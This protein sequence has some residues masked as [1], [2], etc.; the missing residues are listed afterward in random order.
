[1]VRRFV[2]I[3]I[4]LLLPVLAF[5]QGVPYRVALGPSGAYW[6]SAPPPT[7]T[8][9]PSWWNMIPNRN[10]LGLPPS[11]DCTGQ[12]FYLRQDF[13]GRALGYA[14][15]WGSPKTINL[16]FIFIEPEVSLYW[17]K[18]KFSVGGVNGSIDSV[19]DLGLA[20]N[21]NV[22][23]FG[24]NLRSRDGT[25]FKYT[26]MFAPDTNGDGALLNPITIGSTT[27]PAGRRVN[28]RHA[29]G[30]HRWELETQWITGSFFRMHPLIIGELWVNKLELNS[31]QGATFTLPTG[32]GTTGTTGTVN[33]DR[34]NDIASDQK[35][36]LGTG[37]DADWNFTKNTLFRTKYAYMFM[38]KTSGN[39]VD[40]SVVHKY[41]DLRLT[42]GYSFR[43][44]RAN[45]DI[46]IDAQLDGF[47]IQ[48]SYL[49]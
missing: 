40:F 44:S 17:A 16:R 31:P 21:R 39:F 11:V 28:V 25:T 33:Q 12:D 13:L 10:I 7:P 30:L 22:W 43:R 1:M 3:V 49:F 36:L 45:Y 2:F 35:F 34:L 9:V 41:D 8:Q 26:Y 6:W 15:C 19:N 5:G 14:Q 47:Y 23:A 42:A 29:F 32:T 48:M 27:F 24:I 38:N 18:A 20:L 4:L 46:P 37:V